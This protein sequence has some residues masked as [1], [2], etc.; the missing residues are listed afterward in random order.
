[1]CGR[2]T[3]TS[4]SKALASAF[5]AEFAEEQE[6]IGPRYNIPPGSAIPVIRLGASMEGRP[7]LERAVWGLVAWPGGRA[8]PN[9]RAEGLASR[10]TFK[11]AFAARRC[12]V[13]ANGFYEWDRRYQP[14]KPY[15][16]HSPGEVLPMAGIWEW[17]ESKDGKPVMTVAVVT[18]EAADP[19]RSIHDRMPLFIAPA[20]W[21]RWL[22]SGATQMAPFLDADPVVLCQRSVS[23]AVNDARRDGAELIEP[24]EGP[25]GAHYQADLFEG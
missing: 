12:L 1:M 15:Y 4:D 17:Q 13:P 25:T 20:L 14:R 16:F 8:H 21:E 3:V 6:Q 11:A 9:A 7:V 23:L 22:R 2:F 19:V 10:P 5:L 24:L 18:R